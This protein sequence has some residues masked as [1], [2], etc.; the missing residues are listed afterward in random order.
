VSKRGRYMQDAVPSGVG[1][2]AAAIL[3]YYATKT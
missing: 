3:H 2:M 1:A